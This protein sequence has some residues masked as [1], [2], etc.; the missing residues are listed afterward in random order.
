MA[1][2]KFR[3]IL[4]HPEEEETVR[5]RYMEKGLEDLAKVVTPCIY[6]PKGDLMGVSDGGQT[7][8][9]GIGGK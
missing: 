7:V 8:A 2:D 5:K 4:V 9:I 1:I 6:V 3:L